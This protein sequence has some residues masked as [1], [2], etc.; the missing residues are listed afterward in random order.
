MLVLSHDDRRAV[1]NHWNFVD[2]PSIT[3][4]DG[5]TRHDAVTRK[6]ERT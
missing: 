3:T 1:A 4:P 2:R 6:D 5:D